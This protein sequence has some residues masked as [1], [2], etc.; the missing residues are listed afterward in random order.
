M[1]NKLPE[2]PSLNE[3]FIKYIF[4]KKGIK[5]QDVDELEIE[6]INNITEIDNQIKNVAEIKRAQKEFHKALNYGRTTN[7]GEISPRYE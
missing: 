3:A 5:P 6:L 4:L 2:E 1:S 7:Q